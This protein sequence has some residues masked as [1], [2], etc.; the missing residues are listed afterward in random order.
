MKRQ[1]AIS[2]PAPRQLGQLASASS[3]LTRKFCRRGGCRAPKFGGECLCFIYRS[4]PDRVQL[5]CAG[6]IAR[7]RASHGAKADES[8][9]HPR[10]LAAVSHARCSCKKMGRQSCD[11]RPQVLQGT[12]VNRKSV[13]GVGALA[14]AHRIEAFAFFFLLDA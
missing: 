10:I 8:G 3:V 7:H 1:R 14:V 5:P 11:C 12:T 9:F 13:V 4:I 6:E 2:R